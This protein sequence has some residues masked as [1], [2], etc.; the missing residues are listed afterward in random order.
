MER[1][2]N[3]PFLEPDRGTGMIG[4]AVKQL[5]MWLVGG[6]IVYSVVANH[7]LFGGGSAPAQAPSGT[8]ASADDDSPA[9][10]KLVPLGQAA[11]PVVNSLSLRARSDG[12]AWV[13]AVVNGAP[14]TM[15]FD[16]GASYVSLSEADAIKAGVAG[17]LNYSVPIW[18]ANGSNPGAPVMLREIRIG[19]LVIEDVHAIVQKN[20]PHSLLGQ[21]FLNRLHSFEMR[22]GILTLTWE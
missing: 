3:N 9:E 2:R 17:N 4:W 16:T 18:T 10:K 20:L 5:A 6:F 14:M 22:N 11:A 21:S 8:V 1:P 12:Y 19:Q 15:A 13:D 7:H